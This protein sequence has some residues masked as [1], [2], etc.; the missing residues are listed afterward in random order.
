MPVNARAKVEVATEIKLHA[1]KP[2][3]S[4]LIFIKPNAPHTPANIPAQMPKKVKF[5]FRMSYKNVN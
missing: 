2:F 1:K 5:F 4:G 3:K